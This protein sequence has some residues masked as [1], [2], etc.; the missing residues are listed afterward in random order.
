VAQGKK[1]QFYAQNP[2]PVEVRKTRYKLIAEWDM[3]TEKYNAMRLAASKAYG[4]AQHQ[5]ASA[6]LAAKAS[7]KLAASAKRKRDV[8]EA[9]KA[10]VERP[11]RVRGTGYYGVTATANRKR[12][13]AQIHYDN[14]KHHLGTFDTKQEAALAYDRAVLQ[15]GKDRPVNYESIEA[16][17]DAAVRAQAE[18]TLAHPKEPKSR[19]ASASGFYG[20]TASAVQAQAEHIFV[21]FFKQP[22]PR[23]ASGFYGVVANK[24]RWQARITYDH[25]RHSLGTFDTKQEAALAYDDEQGMHGLA[26][27]VNGISQCII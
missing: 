17:E 1:Q 10:K 9:A 21:P 16:A 3:E 24:K 19:S 12:W 5:K 13:E 2:F 6:E 26:W 23:P 18:Y 8:E 11:V 25:K 20:V 14:R 27:P 4:D 15:S 22:K 7:A